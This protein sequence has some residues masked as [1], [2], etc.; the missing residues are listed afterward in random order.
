MPHLRLSALNK[1]LNNHYFLLIY[2]SHEDKVKILDEEQEKL[3]REMGEGHRLIFGVAGSGKTVVLVARA[4]ILAKR[5]PD[6][7]ILI[8]CY[9]R[10]LKDLLFNLLNPQ[11]FEADI[12]ISTF[13]GWARSYIMNSPTTF[14]HCIKKLKTTQ[15]KK[16]K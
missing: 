14:H 11:D 7:K 1:Q 8:L 4:R 6:W 16:I 5:H 3:A 15:K 10:L 9:N 12:T 13:H 2:F